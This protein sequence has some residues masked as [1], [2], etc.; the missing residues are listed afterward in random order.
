MPWEIDGCRW[1][2]RDRV[3]RSGHPIRWNGEILRRIVEQIEQSELFAPT[4]WNN[5]SIVEIRA[6]K[7]SLGWFFHALTS[8]EWLLKMKF[9]TAQNTFRK[10]AI[11]QLLDLKPLNDVDEVPLYGTEPRVRVRRLPGPWQE[12]E[13]RVYSLHEIDRP[14]FWRF[15]ESAVNGFGKF[16]E[17]MQRKP[18]ELMPWKILG[19]K[20][21]F[22]PKGLVGGEKLLWDVSLLHKIFGIIRS[23][24]PQAR[25]VWSN[26]VL[27][28][29][30]REGAT[31]QKIDGRNVPWVV[32]HTKKVD[33]VH[34]DLYAPKYLISQGRIRALGIHPHVH[35]ENDGYDIV[36]LR[37]QS[38]KD[39]KADEFRAL[40][41]MALPLI[42]E[43]PRQ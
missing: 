35:G 13:L 43:S 20:W 39:I 1:H 5:R 41:E 11:I 24:A 19:E 17:K 32:V 31:R 8:E 9:R 4:N 25:F 16:T 14:E 40:L 42:P 22:L 33:A 38:E 27:V 28:P 34:I 3:S 2:T 23:V 6:E 37:F 18:D 10:D 30:Y 29:V 21:H 36:R 7:K 26:K 12:I 15:I